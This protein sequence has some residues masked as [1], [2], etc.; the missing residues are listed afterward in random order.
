MVD[1][2]T[3][4][5]RD[6]ASHLFGPN[7]YY[8]LA[9]NP[10]TWDFLG[11]FD[12]V[13]KLQVIQHHPERW[14]QDLEERRMIEVMHVLAST[15]PPCMDDLTCAFGSKMNSKL[16]SNSRSV[17]LLADCSFLPKLLQVQQDLSKSP[18]FMDDARM[19]TALVAL[20]K[21]S[22]PKLPTF[23]S[24]KDLVSHLR[25]NNTQLWPLM[26]NFVLCAEVIAS[27]NHSIFRVINTAK[28][29]EDLVAKLTQQQQ[30]IKCLDEIHRSSKNQV[31]RAMRHIVHGGGQPIMAIWP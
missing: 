5:T 14:Q 20:F 23:S 8:K 24:L 4:Q 21:A 9:L 31:V 25:D 13:Q 7:V 19:G 15:S 22:R 16:A 27:S 26:N 30:E 3:P 17:G 10:M 6:L 12:F 18:E 11:D 2:L 1:E 28:P 29:H